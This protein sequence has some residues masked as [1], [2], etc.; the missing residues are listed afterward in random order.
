MLFLQNGFPTGFLD[1]SNVNFTRIM[2]RSSDVNNPR[3][4]VQQ[5][6]G[7][8]EHQI[9]HDLVASVD[10]V[11]SN[12]SHLAVLRNI[13]QNLPGTT[14]ANGPLPYPAFGNVQ[15]REMTGKG[16]YRG[17]DM[18]FEKRFSRGYSYRASY[19]IG[20]PKDS[21]PEH[22]NASSGR[23]QNGRDLDSWYGRATSTSV[24]ALS[25]TSSRSCRS[26]KPAIV[27]VERRRR[28]LAA[29]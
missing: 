22:L 17:V 7:G 14:N 5:Y 21:A 29:G 20:D 8:F 16:R 19:T 2:I 27:N 11:G 10:F 26:A 3:T 15:W 25:P 28:F 12:T 23:P 18:S 13:N 9:G 1:P 6:G 24:I 4:M